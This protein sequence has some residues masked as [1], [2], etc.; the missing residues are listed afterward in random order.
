MKIAIIGAS[1][2]GKSTFIQQ[3]LT[4]WHMYETPTVT[5][6]DAVV[7]NNLPI[8]RDGNAD[9][10]LQI[11]NALIEQALDMTG[12]QH[13]IHNRCI[14]DNLAYSLQLAAENEDAGITPQFIRESAYLAQKTVKLY[15]LIFYLPF[16]PHYEV[17][18][19]ETVN[20]SVRTVRDNDPAYKLQIDAIFKL[21]YEHNIKRDGVIFDPADSPPIIPLMGS[22]QEKLIQAC[23]YVDE[24]GNPYDTGVLL[25][26]EPTSPIIK[27]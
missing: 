26:N 4:K 14:L 16:D 9:A 5:Y 10:Q 11:R 24:H 6:R 3:F 12:K 13:V 27:P 20:E 8:N 22:I 25:N 19:E 18:S 15:D 1:G 17:N 21:F 7:E 2:T 23:L